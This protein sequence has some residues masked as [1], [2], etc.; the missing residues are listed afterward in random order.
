MWLGS[1]E[2]MLRDEKELAALL[3]VELAEEW[4]GFAAA[5]EAM[6]PAYEHLKSHPSIL[7][8]WTRSA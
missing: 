3:D 2:A 1:F 5:K 7:G 8:W 6:P 4:L